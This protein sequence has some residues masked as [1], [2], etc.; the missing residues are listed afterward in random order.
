MGNDSNETGEQ[1][2]E[3]PKGHEMPVPEREEFLRG[4]FA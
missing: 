4:L 2:Q 1:K 3:T